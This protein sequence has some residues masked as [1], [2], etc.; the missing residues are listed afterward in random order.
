M[1]NKNDFIFGESKVFGEEQTK[2]ALADMR[3][4]F[5]GKASI[6][7]KATAN[8][9]WWKLRHWNVLADTNEGAKAGVEV[10]SAWLFNSLINKQ[11]DIMDSF[12]KPNILPREA[13]DEIEAR[14]LSSIVPV[15]M[16]HNDYEKTYGTKGLDITKDGTAIT[17]VLWDNTK[18]DGMGDVSISNVDVHN[19]AWKPGIEDIQD[20]DK[21]YYARLEDIDVAKAKWSKLADKISTQDTGTIVQ[22]I[23]DDNV[24]TTNCVE[25]VDMYY[26]KPMLVPVEMEGMD[27]EGNVIKHKLYDMPKMVLHLAIFVGGHLAWCSE[28]E[29]GYENGFYEHGKYPFVFAVR[30]PAKD[31]PCGFGDLD[32]MKHPQ[33]DID[34]L[35]Q[36]IIKNAMMKGRPRYWYRKNANI[37]EDEFADWD[38]ELVE[39]ATG[40]LGDAVRIIDVPDVPAGAMNHMNNKIEELKETSGNRDF[41]QGGVSGGITAA[42][43]VAALQEAGSKLSRRLNKELYRSYREEV[44]LVIELIRQFYTEPR[45]FRVDAKVADALQDIDTKR[46]YEVVG[47]G[48]DYRFIQYSNAGIVEQDVRL[49]DGT[50][51]HRRPIF[52]IQ[53]TAEKS[54]PFSRAA[55]NETIKEL[56]GM[57][58]FAPENAVPALVCLDGM[59]FEGKDKLKQQIEQNSIFLQQFQSAMQLIQQEAMMN[60][61]FGMAAVQQGLLDPEQMAQQMQAQAP[62][63]KQGKPSEGT[64]EERAAKATAGGGNTQAAKARVRAANMAI[65][66]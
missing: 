31:S 32:V 16:E 4:Y 24:D 14:I 9:E 6:D 51:R 52:D 54:S 50:V 60:P 58:L 1:E 5:A 39:V 48:T 10:G 23:H 19:L 61:Q 45:S 28:N 15:I 47:A 13:D 38:N 56:Y 33:R 37:N 18:H 29:E 21:V 59:D 27:E 55:Q 11:A 8:E 66:R 49:E 63:P 26:K 7:A 36:A 25:V 35:D 43:A 12:P 44:Y 62:Q 65:P 64:A 57:G 34:R 41:N 17:S 20:S 30:F 40:D 46:G 42:S 2:I 53:I 22:Y 3:E